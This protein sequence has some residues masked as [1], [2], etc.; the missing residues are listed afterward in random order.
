MVLP[1]PISSASR[2]ACRGIRNATPSSWYGYGGNGTVICLPTNIDSTGGC[3]RYSSR[4]LNSSVS[5]VGRRG[6][7]GRR[8]GWFS[9]IVGGGGNSTG[10][11]GFGGGRVASPGGTGNFQPSV[12]TANLSA[13]RGRTQGRSAKRRA[14]RTPAANGAARRGSVRTSA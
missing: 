5:L 13:A 2:A 12:E 9:A 11:G 14:S 3:N 7:R 8:G 10:A 1:R 4:S 6:A